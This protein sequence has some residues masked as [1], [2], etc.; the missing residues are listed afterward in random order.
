M[1]N[2]PPVLVD[3]ATGRPL[4]STHDA[5]RDTLLATIANLRASQAAVDAWRT[6]A[7]Q[8]TSTSLNLHDEELRA[9]IAAR[10]AVCNGT[11]DHLD[12]HR[13]DLVESLHTMTEALA[14]AV[15]RAVAA[16]GEAALLRAAL[17]KRD[18]TISVLRETIAA[19]S[20]REV[21]ITEL[22]AKDRASIV[23]FLAAEAKRI[24][25]AAE[26]VDDE[27]HGVTE[28]RLRAQASIGRTWTAQIERGDDRQGGA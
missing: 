15:T 8:S 27:D 9:R 3:A 2:N 16:E 22:R 21:T 11:I 26:R 14:D 19:L 6:W 4:L 10:I 17:A 13:R 20:E 7:E 18:A 28:K 12:A 1:A 23:A 24:D 25:D 5:E